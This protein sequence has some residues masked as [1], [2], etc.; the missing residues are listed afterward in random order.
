M[1]KKITCSNTDCKHNNMDGGCKT[2]VKIGGDGSCQSFEKGFIY[3]I[4][5][6][7]GALANKN[8]IDF[9]ELTAELRIG[10]YY[11]MQ[12]YSLG[13]S[14]AEWGTCR[15]LM[16]KDGED[17]KAL[18]YEEIVKREMNH[19][20]FNSLYDDFYNGIIPGQ[21]MNGEKPEPQEHGE[22]ADL[23]FGWLSPGGEFTESPFGHHEESAESICNSKGWEDEYF[24]WRKEH[25]GEDRLMGDFLSTEKGYCLIH[26]PFGYGGYIVTHTKRLTKKQREFL[27][28]YFMDKGDR[29][30]AE[31]FLEEAEE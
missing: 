4:H 9:N 3:Y 25:S 22:K 15:M 31:Q 5:L 6:V 16:L 27:Y 26:N 11:V 17:G 13:F 8:F 23:D 10:L 18:T 12:I 7:W 30:K 28:G 2:F 19:E 29:F 14:Q 24:A 21:N 20:K 1:P